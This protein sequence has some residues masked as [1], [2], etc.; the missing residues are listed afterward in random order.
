M[1]RWVYNEKRQWPIEEDK[2]VQC[3]LYLI[4]R[5]YFSDIKYEEPTDKFGHGYSIV[6]LTLPS[7]KVLIEVKFARSSKDFSKIEEEIKNDSVNYTQ[8]TPY[9]K[10]IVFIYDNNSSVQEH[11]T[12]ITALKKI[13]KTQ[14]YSSDNVDKITNEELKALIETLGLLKNNY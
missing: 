5:S 10:I 13:E 12:T 4:L 8:S 1:Q 2:D 14:T 6:D 7:L 9:K 11:Q 3:I